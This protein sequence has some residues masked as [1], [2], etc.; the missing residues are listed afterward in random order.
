MDITVLIYIFLIFNLFPFINS[1]LNIKFGNKFIIKDK[2]IKKQIIYKL[3]FYQQQ[4]VN[5]ING[6]YGLIGPDVNMSTINNLFDLFIGDGNIQGV[7]LNNG[8]ITFVKHFIRTDKLLYEEINGRIPNNII[9]KLLFLLFSKFGILPD[10]MGLANTALLNIKNK[11]YALYERDKPYLLD[12]NFLNKEITTIDKQD[13][14]FIDH[15]SAHSKYYNKT[16]ETID[17]DILSNS[18][19]YY[20]LNENFEKIKSKNIKTNF[21][22]VIHDFMIKNDKLIFMDSP[23]CIHIDNIFKKK[24]PVLLDK[25]QNTLIHIYNTINNSIDTYNTNNSFYI[26]HYADYVET[27]KSIEIYGSLYDELDFSNL[28]IKGNYRKIQI[29]KNS[30]E[31]I[32]EKN[33]E[34]EKYDLDFPINFDNKIIFRN[35]HNMS[36]NGFIIVEKMKIIK[37]LLFNNIFIC[38]EPAL[39]NIDETPYIIFFGFSTLSTLSTFSKRQNSIF[40]INLYTYQQIKIPIPIQLNIGFHSIYIPS[41]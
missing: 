30:K 4:I 21:M 2:E 31:I 27:N 3:P 29:N 16:I 34:L 17:Y 25:K 40:L 20:Q 37:K 41:Y 33:S 7:F 6:F 10:I 18:V 35:I 32:I 1:F 23:I 14:K 36:I 24:I 39:I 11:C 22:P 19:N 5:K 26:F 13:I 9:L 15:I 38:G 8:N 12:I 28:N